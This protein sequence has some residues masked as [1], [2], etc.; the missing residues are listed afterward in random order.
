MK[1]CGLIVEYNPLHNGH[2]YHIQSA[3]KI[4]KADCIIAIMSGSFLQRG[5]PAL[6]DKFYR[7]KSALSSGIDI[8]LELPYAFAVQNSDLFAH[9]AIHSLYEIGVDTI[10][11]GSESGDVNHF[12]ESYYKLKEHKPI[13]QQLLA[14]HLKQGSSYP[15]ASEIA[16]QEIGLTKGLNLAKPN[17]IL[18]FSYVKTILDENLPI[19]PLTIKRIKSDYH[20][21]YLQGPIAS[22]TSIREQLHKNNR[23]TSDIIHSLPEPSI[24]QIKKYRKQSGQW[25]SW[26]M[27]FPFLQYRVLTTTPKQLASIQ[28]VDEG[29]EY[30]IISTAKHATSFMNWMKRLK[31]KRYTW[32]RLQR[33]FTHILTNTKKRDIDYISKRKIPYVRLLGFTSTGQKYLRSMKKQMSTPIITNIQRKSP[34][35]LVLE[36]KASNAYYSILQPDKRKKFFQQELHPPI[37]H[38]S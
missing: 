27:Y 29:I 6:I 32:T 3:K 28:G 38:S 23:L 31:T 16:F 11:F 33:M 2:V 17:N 1:A 30:R 14:K 4:S 13:Y 15:K 37:F 18:G 26:E 21:T 19:T 12:I 24:Q 8:V 10:C 20:D 35:L 9:G 22:A 25:H 5:E 7:T 34:H 36:E